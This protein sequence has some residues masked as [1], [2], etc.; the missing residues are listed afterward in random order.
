VPIGPSFAKYDKQGRG[1]ALGPSA[2][3]PGETYTWRPG[4]TGADTP[5]P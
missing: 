3:P 1:I 5:I 2:P 4:G